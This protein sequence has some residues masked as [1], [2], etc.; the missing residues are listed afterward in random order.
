MYPHLV[1]FQYGSVAETVAYDTVLETAM[2]AQEFQ[3]RNL[4]LHGSWKWLVTEFA[5]YYGVSDAYTR[6]RY[7][8]LFECFI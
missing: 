1:F 6:L 8:N 7:L 3:Q 4:L 2:K 5:S